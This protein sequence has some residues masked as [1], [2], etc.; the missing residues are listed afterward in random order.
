LSGIA[1]SGGKS[2]KANIEGGATSDFGETSKNTFTVGDY[3]DVVFTVY[4]EEEHIGEQGYIYVV[5]SKTAG[6]KKSFS[7]LSEDGLWESWG[8]S[9]KALQPARVADELLEAET[10]L[11][12]SGVAEEGDL[13]IYVGYALPFDDKPNIHFNSKPFKITIEGQ[14]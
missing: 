1:M 7:Y 14:N 12:Y 8:G 10:V 13:K 5:L 2:S 3:I 9:L 6:K 11:A 4:P